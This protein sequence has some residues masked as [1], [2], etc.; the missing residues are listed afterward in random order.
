MQLVD[1]EPRERIGQVRAQS[2]L[3]RAG[4]RRRVG[5]LLQGAEEQV[6]LLGGAGAE[7]V[8]P[9]QPVERFTRNGR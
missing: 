9:R 4:G 3:A 2:V 5:L 7:R 1:L 6:E 8:A